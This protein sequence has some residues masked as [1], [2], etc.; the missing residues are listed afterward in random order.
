MRPGLLAFGD[1]LLN[2]ALFNAVFYVDLLHYQQVVI[3]WQRDIPL[4]VAIV[5]YGALPDLRRGSVVP[6]VK[7]FFTEPVRRDFYFASRVEGVQGTSVPPKY[8]IDFPDNAVRLAVAVVVKGA[9]A[10]V[11]AE[12][13]VGAAVHGGAARLAG[14]YVHGMKVHDPRSRF[15]GGA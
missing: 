1:W 5:A 11:G 12:S 3:L 10:L 2:S 7:A 13:L 6:E 14:P 9:P 8:G 15:S 4:V